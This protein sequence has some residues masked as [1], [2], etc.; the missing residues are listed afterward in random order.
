M[1]FL[2]VL[3]LAILLVLLFA[4]TLVL[5][6][7]LGAN[8]TVLNPGFILGALDRANFYQTAR[9]AA[10]AA[11]SPPAGAQVSRDIKILVA[12]VEEALTPDLIREQAEILIPRIFGILKNP[13]AEAELV[14]D[15]T[16]F[17]EKLI[18][19]LQQRTGAPRAQLAELE[20]KIPGKIDLKQYNITPAQLAQPAR[21]Y[22]YFE[23]GLALAVALLVALG[24]VCCLVAG[25]R[26]WGPWLGVP[27]ILSGLA[28][29]TLVVAARRT[30][31]LQLADPRRF[32]IPPVRGLDPKVIAELAESVANNILQT[33]FMIGVAF[34]GL[35]VILWVLWAMTTKAPKKPVPGLEAPPKA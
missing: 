7:A 23:Q 17:R 27:F 2:R 8:Q 35:G 34:A 24:T 3:F 30:I 9:D 15:L 12:A 10:V 5:Q 25:R 33:L 1:R 11:L 21:Y 28:A 32:P 13:S 22:R 18:G 6:L 19:V 16:K 4:N 26:A 14:V 20:E 31:V 29:G